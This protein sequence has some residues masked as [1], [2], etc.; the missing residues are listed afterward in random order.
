MKILTSSL[1]VTVSI[2]LSMVCWGQHSE[3]NQFRGPNASGIAAPDAKPPVKFGE[4]QNLLWKIELPYGNSSPVVWEDKIFLT[5]FIEEKSELQTLCID[6]KKG[7]IIWIDSIFPDKLEQYH[8]ISSP[9]QATVAVDENSV[10][11]FFGSEGLR[12]L[13]HNGTLKWN[14]PIP[15][16]EF[17]WGHP[18]SPVIADEKLII[19]MDHGSNEQRHLLALNKTDGSVIWKSFIQE[20]T[21]FSTYGYPCF[22]TPAIFQDQIILHRSGGVASYSLTTGAPQWWIHLRTNGAGTPIVHNNIIFVAGWGE[23]AEKGRRGEFYEYDTFEKAVNA[24]DQDGDKLISRNEIPEG[25]MITDRPENDISDAVTFSLRNF[26]GR[27]DSDKNGLADENEWMSFYNLIIS[28]T[29]DVGLMAFNPE[30]KGELTLSDILWVQPEKNPEVPSPLANDDCIYMVKNGGWVTCMDSQTGKVHYQEKLGAPGAY[31]ASPVAAN[32]FI[33][34]PAHNG[35]I[36]VIE[37]GKKPKV[38]FETKLKGKITATP[39]IAENNL[40]IRTSELLYAFGK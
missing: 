22:G 37:A 25:M 23:F 21:P 10:Y 13:D 11:V 12:C 39:A 17:K 14:Y 24:L 31:I 3:W 7:N 26:Y 29:E 6:R 36:N 20:S 4:G 16:T 28:F 8:S 2:F 33:Y 34:L 40:Y 32:G 9:A 18:S 38:V 5:G 15:V 1:L 30:L 19:T 27:I 35:T